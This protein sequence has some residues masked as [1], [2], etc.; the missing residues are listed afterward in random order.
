MTQQAN[1]HTTDNPVNIDALGREAWEGFRAFIN[2]YARDSNSTTLVLPIDGEQCQLVE[3]REDGMMRYEADEGLKTAPFK[4]AYI[5][6][7]VE[8]LGKDLNLQVQ[9]GTVGE[10]RE[11]AKSGAAGSAGRATTI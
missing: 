4:A 10:A 11:G 8:Q 6:P 9:F 2:A 5:R 7:L 1:A 3:I